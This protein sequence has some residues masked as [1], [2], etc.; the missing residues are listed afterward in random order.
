[1]DVKETENENE[2]WIHLD[3]DKKYGRGPVNKATSLRVS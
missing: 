1:M 3:Q 2:D